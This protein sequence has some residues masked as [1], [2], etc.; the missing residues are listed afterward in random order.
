MR[1]IGKIILALLAFVFLL[2]LI[3][4]VFYFVEAHKIKEIYGQL[5]EKPS[6]LQV[7]GLT[8]RDLNKNGQLDVYEDYRNPT[9]ARVEDLL[10][11]MT[12]EEKAGSMFISMIGMT[13]EGDHL[14]LPPLSFDPL[15]IVFYTILSPN[16]EMLVH[17]KMNHFNIINSYT[18]D[19]LAKYNNLLQEKAARSRLGIPITIATDPRHG[20]KNNPGAAIYTPSFSQWPSSLG[21]AATR[22]T[23]LVRQFGEIAREDY[24]A[25]GIRLALHPMADLAT[26]PRWGR[27]NGT[28]GEDAALS[29]AMT[30][31]YVKGFQGDTLS[32]ES[33]ICMTKHFSGGGPQ[34]DGE[35][36]HFPYGREQVYPGNNFDY[37]VRPFVEGAFPANTGQIMPYYGI[38]MGQTDEDVAFGFNKQIITKMLRDSLKFDGVICTDWNIVNDKGLDTARA[39]GVED[40]SPEERMLKVIEAGC[41]Q[42]GGEDTPEQLIALV[43]EGKLSEERIDVSVR[44][45]LRDKFTIGLF[46]NPYV[47]QEQALK[48]ATAPHKL[49][50]AEK[51]QVKSTILLKNE[52]VLPL[53]KNLKIL[54][55]GFE[56]PTAFSAFA[57]VV[58]TLEEADVVLVKRN[59]PFD[60]RND[61]F[62]EQF[63]HQGRL[64]FTPEEL[65]P[66]E[67]YAKE[68]PVITIVNLERAAILTDIANFSQG[69]F[70]EFGTTEATMVKILFGEAS[71]N[72]KLP[73]ELPRSQMAVEAQFED[74]PYDSENPLFPFGFG[75]K[76]DAK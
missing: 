43:K 16:A 67:A 19:I 72:G 30:Y 46:E 44:R 36:A 53:N 34:K 39:W 25:A 55:D 76:Y 10:S 42:F 26:E 15:N 6:T 73:I 74:V 4:G 68:K 65:A 17:K 24:K 13:S 48:I 8:F 18:P 64:Y 29:A 41:D 50:M 51:A 23:T 20:N 60:E 12:L 56:D 69:L 21:L 1:I 57:T 66:I 14:D 40:L 45:L 52:A 32:K 61:Y 35:D 38:P 75:L 9:P 5:G 33:V 37:H 22:D 7:D 27:S 47:D 31:A 28:F 49:K 70:V 62:L 63:F 2:F 54:L 71:P 11:Q 3:G 58:N 59:T